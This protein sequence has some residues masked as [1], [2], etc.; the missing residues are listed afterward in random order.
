MKIQY[1]KTLSEVTRSKFLLLSVLIGFSAV[2][3]GL[4]EGLFNLVNSLLALCALILMH[5]AVNCFNSAS[6]YRTGID[7]ET[8]KTPFSG[9]ITT[10]VEGNISYINT[11]LIGLLA[12][13]L[14]LPI[15]IYFSYYLDSLIVISIF[16][17][18][19][20]ISAGYTDFFARNYMGEI[21]AGLGLG[22][23]PFFLIFYVQSGKITSN[24]IYL[25]A[26]MFIPTF[27]LLLIN[28]FPDID[29]DKKKGRKNIPILIGKK[30]AVYVHISSN[31]F[32]SV[33]M[34]YLAYATSLPL[35]IAILIFPSLLSLKISHNI[36]QNDFEVNLQDMKLNTLAVHSQFL[37]LGMLLIK[38][39]LI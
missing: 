3:L 30:N 7:K 36:Y 8:E 28:E 19:I 25:S 23:L 16:L 24:S 12:I 22:S 39:T 37:F 1:I 9:G 15:F 4:Y 20:I 2:A 32:L 33:S 14:T 35:N 31:I 13:T 27:T 17:I 6:D 29:V 38:S 21:V 26:L 10:L 34:V 5:I 18:G 11:V